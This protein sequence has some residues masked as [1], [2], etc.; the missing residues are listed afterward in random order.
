MARS[1]NLS[2]KSLSTTSSSSLRLKPTASSLSNVLALVLKDNTDM[3]K[4]FA[5]LIS[6]PIKPQKAL[7]LGNSPS[8]DSNKLKKLNDQIESLKKELVTL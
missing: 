1:Q 4:S 2:G 3:K 7:P 5:Q 8:T 6:K